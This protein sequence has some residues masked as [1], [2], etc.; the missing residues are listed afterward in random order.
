MNPQVIGQLAGTPLVQPIGHSWGVAGSHENP[1]E[2]RQHPAQTQPNV[3]MENTPYGQ[4]AVPGQE[5]SYGQ[6]GNLHPVH[7]TEPATEPSSHPTH[8]KK[9]F[10]FPLGFAVCANAAL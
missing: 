4:L 6:G 8:P 3:H 7:R 2:N 10:W 1:H 5:Q 9:L